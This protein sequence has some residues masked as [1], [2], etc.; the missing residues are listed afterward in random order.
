MTYSD[1]PTQTELAVGEV[2]S[3][4]AEVL[5]L[6]ESEIDPDSPLISL[7]LESFTVVRLRRRL[8]ERTGVDLPLTAFLGQA[9]AASV[10]AAAGGPRPVEGGGEAFPLTPAQAAC[11]AGWDQSVLL[12]GIAEFSYYEYERV[13]QYGSPEADLER[14]ATAWNRLVAHHPMLRVAVGEDGW[15]RVLPAVEPY[16]IA[17]TDLRGAAPEE[18]RGA[19]ERLRRERSHR[20]CPSGAWPPFDIHAVLLPGGRIRLGIGVDA[21]AVDLASWAL[22]MRQWGALVAD[23]AAPLPAAPIGFAE[24]ARRWAREASA[25][26]QGAPGGLDATGGWPDGPRLPLARPLAEIGA[27]RFVRHAGA[28]SAADWS[29]LRARIREQGLSPTGTLLAAFAL[30]LARWG[31]TDR[32]SLLVRQF[33]RPGDE[34]G[35]EHVV[36][37]FTTAVPVA[38]PVPDLLSWSGFAQYAAA[39]EQRYRSDREAGRQPA[40]AGPP[41]SDQAA[42]PYPVVL[43][44]GVGLAGGTEPPAAWLGEEVFAV[45][46]TPRALLDYRVWEEGGKLRL[47]WDVVESALPEGF[48]AGMLAAHVRLLRRLAGDPTAWSDPSLGWDPSFYPPAPL[49]CAPFPAAGPLLDDPLRQA[50]RQVPDA[51]AILASRGAVTHAELAARAAQTAAA[52]ADLG[53][54]PGDLVAVACEKAP[55]QI[56]AVL[57]VVASGAGYVP[58]E[59][60]WPAARIASVCARAGIRHALVGPGTAAE[61]P[62]TVTVHWLDA[63]GRL[64][65]GRGAPPAGR[66]EPED[67]AYVI[68]TSG[69]TGTPKGVA[70]EHRAARTTVDDITDRFGISSTDRVLALS[71]LSFDLSVYDIFGVL[72]A[73]GAVVLPDADRRLDPQHWLELIAQHQVTVWNTAP[74][75]LEMLV[76]HAEGD[77]EAGRAALAS[78]RL[79]LLSGDWIPV[80]LPDRLRAL[81]PQVRVVSLGG[82][83][84]ASIWSI[85]YPIDSLDPSWA[86]IPYGRPLRGQSFH[87]LD[88]EGRP[89]PVGEA[90]ELYIGGDGLARGYIG[91]P[92]QTAARFAVHQALGERLYRTGDLGRWRFDGTIEF[93][94]RVDRQV[95]I[96]GHRIELGEIESVLNR[97]PEVRQCVAAGVPGPDG[98]PRLV[99]YVALHG[100]DAPLQ[101]DR[102]A[103]ALRE[104]LPAYMIPNRFVRL[105]HFPVTPNG[106][107]DYAALPNPYR[108]RGPAGAAL[109]SPEQRPAAHSGLCCLEAALRDA[110][111]R[112]LDLSVNVSADSLRPIEALLAAG[113]WARWVRE[114]AERCG[115]Q[116]Q[117]RL[118]G[119][120][121]LELRFL[122]PV[123]D[124]LAGP[125]RDG[126]QPECWPS[127]PVSPR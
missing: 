42:P 65:G 54:G 37:A 3:C 12:G 40:L 71:A 33:D 59:P 87:V 124:A 115:V 119:A 56:A 107:V 23:P 62:G 82:A 70:I 104:R 50:A 46:Q 13:P 20:L 103:A 41:G 47:A 1:R 108:A 89:C 101:E 121:L 98:H 90:G 30:T 93:L 6:Q 111:A 17:V 110:S 34:P 57:G 102:L 25:Q 80:T 74:A 18:V 99:A 106:K 39:T 112:G 22:L 9:T 72:G 14:L 91:D 55:A 114:G 60:S 16:R 49:D 81:A 19:L 2:I 63:A 109:A 61:W 84:E 36:G 116:V 28:L 113:E 44:S 8:R 68:F 120:G 26:A 118:S 53:V 92:E 58:V 88:P 52:L 75:L 127:S 69:S 100:P 86:S 24:L 76:E 122:M 51:P 78:L 29:D 21:I 79:A 67:L 66:P 123:G 43:T 11:R 7:G 83:T 38:P 73:G 97:L 96:R 10:A 125:P 4:V 35:I 77:P 48:A 117:E 31:A 64:A 15:Q 126:R 85:C 5:G 45:S 94:G 95:K 27:P 32:F 105:D